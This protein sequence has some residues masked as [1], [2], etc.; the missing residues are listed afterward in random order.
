[1]SLHLPFPLLSSLTIY[2]GSLPST[3]PAL[4]APPTCHARHLPRQGLVLFVPLLDSLF[5][6]MLSS[7]LVCAAKISRFTYLNCNS[8]LPAEHSLILHPPFTCLHIATSDTMYIVSSCLFIV[9]V[10][11]LLHHQ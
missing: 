8:Y 2:P 3:D 11:I 7:L 4:L 6:G 5:P 9:C 10:F 1:M